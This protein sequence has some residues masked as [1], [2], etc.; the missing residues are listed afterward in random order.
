VDAEV[1]RG[2]PYQ[3]FDLE[4]G[5]L[6]EAVYV[7]YQ[8]DFRHYAASSM[9]RRLVQAMTQFGCTTL[10]QLQ[11]QVIHRP[12]AFTRLLG[13]LTVQVSEMF[14]DPAYYRA[15]RREVVPVLRTH[16]SIKVWV[17]GCSTGEELWS[18]LILFHEEGLADRTLFYATDINVESLHRAEAAIYELERVA[19]F[20]ANYL[21]AGGTG[22]LSDYYAAAYGG[23]AFGR[24][25]PSQVVF[26]DHSLATDHVFSE[27]N[28][29]S[30]RNVL[31]Y[32][33]R[34]LQDRALGLFSEALPP[35]GFLG[36]GSKETLRFSGLSDAFADVD[37]NARLY[38][39]K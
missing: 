5:L 8:H 37:A 26:A 34:A 11:D 39:R 17:A 22:S 12:D 35:G 23:A 6:L 30:C 20:S 25:L 1:T 16:P 9:R 31:I 32:F 38:R 27:V 7:K 4:M 13:Y 28:L 15:L 10:S 18:L 29:V 21:E 24:G 2:A 14:R 36:L 3:D 19:R 33:D